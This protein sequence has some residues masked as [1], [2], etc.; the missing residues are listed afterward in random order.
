MSDKNSM[1][2]K[3]KTPKLSFNGSRASIRKNTERRSL[4]EESQENSINV[5]QLDIEYEN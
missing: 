2:L 4:I 5:S 1:K 3:E